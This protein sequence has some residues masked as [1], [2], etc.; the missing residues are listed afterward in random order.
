MESGQWNFSDCPSMMEK[1]PASFLAL[2]SLQESAFKKHKSCDLWKD[3]LP[4]T[5][6][7]TE[8]MR[9][10]CSQKKLQ[11]EGDLPSST[12]FIL[13]VATSTDHKK[14]SFIHCPK[15][16]QY[17]W[18]QKANQCEPPLWL[19]RRNAEPAQTLHHRTARAVSSAHLRSLCVKATLELPAGLG[20]PFHRVSSPSSL[21]SRGLPAD[22]RTFLPTAQF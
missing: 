18:G 4:W 16:N 3:L 2:L 21:W 5:Q 15:P 1:H 22:K 13:Q 12:A 6:S 14:S 7:R 9:Q 17:R 11:W 10:D 19:P 20:A 8:D